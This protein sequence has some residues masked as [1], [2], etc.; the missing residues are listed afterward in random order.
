MLSMQKISTK[1]S[2]IYQ[3]TCCCV[4]HFK[5]KQVF[6]RHRQEERVLCCPRCAV[7]DGHSSWSPCTAAS[8]HVP[9]AVLGYAGHTAVFDSY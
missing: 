4:R 5:Y 2:E 9:A 3:M 6:Y 8:Q 1:K 7:S